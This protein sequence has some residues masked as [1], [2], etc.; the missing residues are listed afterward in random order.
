MLYAGMSMVQLVKKG[1]REIDEIDQGLNRVEKIALDTI[2]VGTNVSGKCQDCQVDGH[3]GCTAPTFHTIAALAAGENSSALRSLRVTACVS[4]V[5]ASSE[6]AF[7]YEVLRWQCQFCRTCSC[8]SPVMPACAPSC[9]ADCKRAER[10]DGQAQ[11]HRGR[12][13]RDGV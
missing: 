3:G 2:D 13:E 10:T 7:G 6:H 9:A 12:P 11:S 4:P 8:L 1:H 5:P